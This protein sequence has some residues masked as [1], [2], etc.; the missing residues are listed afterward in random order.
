MRHFETA[1]REASVIGTMLSDLDRTVQLLDIDIATEEE[2]AGVFDRSQSTYPILARTLATRR[3]NLKNTVVALEQHLSTT[4]TAHLAVPVAASA[5]RRMQRES[6]LPSL[7]S[8][9]NG[10]P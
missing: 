10:Q 1:L 7:S 5:P 2:R 6:A 8:F 9:D 3:D 4:M